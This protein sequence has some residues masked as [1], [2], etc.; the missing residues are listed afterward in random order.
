LSGTLSATV[1]PANV[2]ASQRVVNVAG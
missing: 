1:V 2:Y